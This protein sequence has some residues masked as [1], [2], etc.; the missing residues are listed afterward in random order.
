MNARR[1]A[2]PVRLLA[3]VALA[4][5][6][7]GLGGCLAYDVVALPVKVAYTTAKVT[8]KTVM[9]V[10][11]T[12]DHLVRGSPP[13]PTS[14][15]GAARLAAPGSVTFVDVGTRMVV[16]IPWRP[17]MTVA[18]AGMT[19]DETLARRRVQVIRDGAVVTSF[20][21]FGGSGGRVESGDVVRV[22]T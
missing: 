12:T 7:T 17:G 18:G 1:F 8:G 16:R 14:V 9:F 10:G 21:R 3:G 2:R 13:D 6:A 22:R 4:T 11:R 20:R 15:R 5:A 19:A